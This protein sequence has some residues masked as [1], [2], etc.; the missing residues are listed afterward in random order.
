[1]P[2]TVLAVAH[3]IRRRARRGLRSA[4]GQAYRYDAQGR[5]VRSEVGGAQRRYSLYAQDGRLLWQR[6]EVAATR[7]VNVYL[8]GSLVAEYSRPLSGANASVG[9]LHT[10]P[11]GSPI[12]KT[13]ATGAVVETSEYEPYGLLLNRANDDRAGYTGHVQDSATGLTY[14]QQRYYDPMIG[15]FLSTDP[16]TAYEKPLTNFNRYAYARNNPYRFTDP[17][18]RDSVGEMIDSAAEGCGAVSCAGY[19]VLSA[20][21]KVLGA[22]GV[23]Q[24]ADKGWSNASGGDKASAA[25]EV[26]AV[27]P[28]VKILGEAAGALKTASEVADAAK[29]VAQ[30]KN[31]VA[32]GGREAAKSL[33]READVAGKGGRTITRDATGG[34]RAVVGRTADGKPIR[35]R[36]KPD[37]TTR[38]QAADKKIIFP[39]EEVK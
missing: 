23:S 25:L 30:G 34:G 33:F 38:I 15:R 20:T 22:E 14:M 36:F 2:R 32:P 27:L 24:I 31:I 3:R 17:D 12:A 28:P 11:L 29:G 4:A 37:G 35:I 7:S 19:A 6:D 18:G 8:A 39:K 21:W 13:D 10:D 9:F 5:R 16:V 26:A 1:M